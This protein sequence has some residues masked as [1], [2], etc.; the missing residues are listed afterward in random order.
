MKKIVHKL[1]CGIVL[2]TV[3]AFAFYIIFTKTS[4]N[5]QFYS[6]NGIGA[7]NDLNIYQPISFS[8]NTLF[9]N[10]Q[11]NVTYAL[12]KKTGNLLWQYH[13]QNYSPFPVTIGEKYVYTSNFDGSVYCFD[14]KNG[15][16]IWQFHFPD[17]Y[18]PDTEPVLSTDQK[19]VFVANREGILYALDSQSGQVIWSRQFK[20]IA[21]DKAFQEGT[22]HFGTIFVNDNMLYVKNAIE[23][24]FTAIET[25]SGKILWSIDA[26]DFDFNHPYFFQS[27]IVLT[28]QKNF[29]LI[30]RSDGKILKKV[31]IT[32]SN[33]KIIPIAM[34]D[35]LLFD[36]NKLSRV[37]S[38]TGQQLWTIENVDFLIPHNVAEQN[39]SLKKEVTYIQ[40]IDATSGQNTIEAISLQNGEVLWKRTLKANIFVDENTIN[41]QTVFLSKTGEI[42]SLRS[43]D[44]Q[45][46][47]Q[48]KYFEEMKD[49][50]VYQDTI[51]LVSQ[52][53]SQKNNF[54]LL[55]QSGNELWA[56]SPDFLVNQNNIL[57]N[58]HQLYL[59]DSNKQLLNK[60]EISPTSEPETINFSQLN[61][62]TQ[63]NFS[64]NT[65]YEELLSYQ[66]ISW[67]IQHLYQTMLYALKNFKNIFQFSTNTTYA[68]NLLTFTIHHDQ[69]LF[70]D[71]QKS[72]NIVATLVD[73]Q[74]TT[75]TAKGFYYDQNTWQVR[76]S[77]P[78]TGHYRWEIQINTPL[79]KKIYTG[80][81]DFVTK[82]YS[83]LTIKD[84]VLVD[85]ENHLIQPIGIQQA[86][87]DNNFNGNYLDEFP[88]NTASEP[89]SKK[90]HFR[91]TT[92]QKY[93]TLNKEQAKINFFRLNDNNASPSLYQSLEPNQAVYD[94]RVGW[95]N[96]QIINLLRKNQLFI[97][98]NIFGFYPPF[99]SKTEISQPALQN[100]LTSYLDYVIA[101]YAATIDLWE[102]GN[103]AKS[104][105]NWYQFVSSYVRAHDPYKHPIST[106]WTQ[107]DPSFDYLSVHWYNSDDS[108][109]RE[110][111]DETDYLTQL[112]TT[113]SQ[114]VILT[115]FGFKN[116]SWFPHMTKSLRLLSW[117][118]IFQNR[119]VIFW[120]QGQNGI[121]QN[122]NNANVYLGPRERNMLAELQN[123]LPTFT[124]P[125]NFGQTYNVNTQS[126][127][128]TIEDNQSLAGYLLKINGPQDLPIKLTITVKQAGELKW[129][130]PETGLFSSSQKIDGPGKIDL[131]TPSFSDDLAFLI[132]YQQSENP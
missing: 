40:Q 99:D 4:K 63:E 60:L 116:F 21:V 62:H 68:D 50:Y 119:G 100:E 42:F 39:P 65:P 52:D 79:Q 118:N 31:P 33:W 126:K 66:P 130:N 84:Q 111:S 18:D 97:I 19:L 11:D 113:Y 56:Y 10:S 53:L 105:T 61:F 44:G 128:L 22:I 74:N 37:N 23:K 88:I 124:F 132:T 109:N 96:D 51:L 81:A 43:Q 14:Q 3:M 107:T 30:N 71:A 25:D 69:Q 114:P 55:S 115:E 80:G 92:F 34:D 27:A 6:K 102:I 16:L 131:T 47:W 122:A 17:F 120:E 1:F 112:F 108:E 91:Y 106:N 29:L 45:S 93:I 87:S 86:F 28:Q 54:Y 103:E 13:T 76:F 8:A 35:F 48:K 41:E 95:T 26:I 110:L 127:L 121:Y 125:V 89:L 2:L 90:D 83:T 24:N 49:M 123:F 7:N 15:F 101:R 70:L 20:G 32:S 38:Q 64:G 58:D 73:E 67:S 117:Q 46:L 36:A 75:T 57:Q 85:Q 77:I 78:K 82:N 98:F 12:D 9:F 94:L 5:W 129:F 72:V 59:L 104:D